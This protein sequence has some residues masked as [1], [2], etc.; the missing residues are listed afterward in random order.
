MLA[1]PT[2]YDKTKL[3]SELFL[4]LAKFF[5]IS[6]KLFFVRNYK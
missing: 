4:Y 2:N 5:N 1:F 6:V 3:F